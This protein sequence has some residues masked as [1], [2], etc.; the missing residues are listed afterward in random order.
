MSQQTLPNLAYSWPMYCLECDI[1]ARCR[2]KLEG[3][4][5]S[6]IVRTAYPLDSIGSVRC[7]KCA[8]ACSQSFV[9]TMIESYQARPEMLYQPVVR[10][11]LGDSG[12]FS[13]KRPN[14]IQPGLM[15]GPITL[16]QCRENPGLRPILR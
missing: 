16:T 14:S 2:W 3:N 13:S 9:P 4:Q 7:D 15:S 1:L 8:S 11:F 5:Q 6:H 12:S 10:R